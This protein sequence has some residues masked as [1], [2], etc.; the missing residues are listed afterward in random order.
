MTSN[1]WIA[2]IG[3]GIAAGVNLGGYLVAWGAMKGQVAALGARVGALEGQMRALEELKLDVARLQT[4]LDT[5][6]DQVRDLN[7]AIR[8]MQ[9]RP[10]EARPELQ[11]APR[12]EP[13]AEPRPR[14]GAAAG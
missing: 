8:W 2:L 4:R 12:A 1:D 13:R 3:L 11:P 5:L 10:S 14:R 9:G 7:A 6:I